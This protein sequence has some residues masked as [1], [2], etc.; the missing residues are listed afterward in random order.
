MHKRKNILYSAALLLVLGMASCRVS[1]PPSLPAGKP[2]PEQFP[3]SS[4]TVS[5]GETPWKQFYHDQLL[6]DLV[7]TVLLNNPDQVLAL[8]RVEIMNQQVLQRKAAFLPSVNA[9]LS[10]GLDRYGDYTLN[11][12]GNF[13]TNLSP[14]INKDQKIPGPTPDL[15]LGLRS[16]W[17]IDLWGR[18]KSQKQAAV[19]RFMAAE[20]GRQFI[21]T[22]LVAQVALLYYELIAFDNELEIV[23][24]NMELQ[25]RALEV[26]KIQ[27][28][29]GRATELAVQQFEAQL[30]RTQAMELVMKQQIVAI[31]NELNFLAGRYQ[32]KIERS[33]QLLHTPAP[34][35]IPAGIPSK[36]LLN[37]PDVQEAEWMLVAARADINA[38]RAAFM[39]ALTISPYAGL[40]SFNAARWISPESAALGILGGLTAPVLNRRQLKSDYKIAASNQLSAF[41]I[42]QK[43]MLGAYA[44]I[45]TQIN[46]WRNL[47]QQFDL[48]EKEFM[49]LSSAVQTA[50]DLYLGGYANYLEV[51]TAQKGVLDAELELVTIRLKMLQTKV[52]LYRSLGGGWKM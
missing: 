26:V 41:A 21:T 11:G 29:G 5:S 16:Q 45:S 22:Q 17:E 20:K 50:N 10:A 40:N 19:A 32:A 43:T 2:L 4:D 13:D 35:L 28:M 15:F 52:D 37:R 24:K 7:D 12:V 46:G 47:R 33:R 51:I 39:P 6:K 42:Y 25:A 31:E 9:V 18:L 1:A 34:A 44:E 38:V 14:N 49:V 48:K 23:R 27:K 36:S 30:F 8:Q 3:G